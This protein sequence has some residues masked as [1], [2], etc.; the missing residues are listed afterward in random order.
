MGFYNSEYTKSDGACLCLGISNA[1]LL[2]ILKEF[3]RASLVMVTIAYNWPS[4]QNDWKHAMI[5]VG[6]IGFSSSEKFLRRFDFKFP[7]SLRS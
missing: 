5:S 1:V 2:K 7:P 4:L 3:K 6:I